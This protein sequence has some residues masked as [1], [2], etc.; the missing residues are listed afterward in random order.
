MPPVRT[1][2]A[3]PGAKAPVARRSG[4]GL[5]KSLHPRTVIV[6]IL[7]AIVIAAFPFWGVPLHWYPSFGGSYGGSVKGLAWVRENPASPSTAINVGD[8]VTYRW[9]G[10]AAMKRVWEVSPDGKWFWVGGDNQADGASSGSCEMGWIAL[11][12]ATSAPPAW[13]K[14]NPE[15]AP[16]QAIVVEG[17]VT[18]FWAPFDRRP[19]FEKQARFFNPPERCLVE[20]DWLVIVGESRSDVYERTTGKLSWQVPGKVMQLKGSVASFMKATAFRAD[21]LPATFDLA[22][23]AIVATPAPLVAPPKSSEIDLRHATF[24]ETSGQNPA[25]VFDEDTKSAWRIGAGCRQIE[26]LTIRLPK[27]V[28]VGSIRIDGQC[29]FGTK[30]T[31]STSLN[32][33]ELPV[34]SDYKISR[35]V[36][37]IVLT[38]TQRVHQ[39][40]TGQIREVDVLAPT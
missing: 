26:T 35:K 7:T 24:V 36:D 33:K 20:S 14:P 6:A 19:E 16:T 9:C 39:P 37:T 1:A 32:G 25:K 11:P 5:R 15:T 3:F 31:V 13:P 22:G 29:M 10:K 28:M 23:G 40:V 27:P 34:G 17:I 8:N 2:G 4:A 18:G 38:L 30:L 21:P 12:G